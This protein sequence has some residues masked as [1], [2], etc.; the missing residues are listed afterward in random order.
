MVYASGELINILFSDECILPL[1]E[2]QHHVLYT[3]FSSLMTIG[4]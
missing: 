1:S 3:L 4:I 2:G